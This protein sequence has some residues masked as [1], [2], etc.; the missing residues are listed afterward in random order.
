LKI[1]DGYPILIGVE[2]W[3]YILVLKHEFIGGLLYFLRA[4]TRCNWNRLNI[5]L[6]IC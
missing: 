1:W 6:L 3:Y 2:V 4:T 5:N